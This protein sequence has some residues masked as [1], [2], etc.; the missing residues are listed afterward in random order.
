MGSLLEVN[1]DPRCV[2][3]AEAPVLR[4]WSP[5]RAFRDLRRDPLRFFTDAAR[6]GD[7]VRLQTWFLRAYLVSHP[8]HIRYVLKDNHRNYRNEDRFNRIFQRAGGDG[9]LTTDGDSWRR[10]RRLS[11]PAFSRERA[12][13]AVSVMSAETAAMLE[14]WAA[15]AAIGAQVELC[16]EMTRLTLQ[17]AGRAFCG[18]DM[19][20][21]A[22]TFADAMAVG[23]EHFH[24]R[25]YNAFTIPERIP[26]RRNL[27][28]RAASRIAV[29]FI[30][31]VIEPVLGGTEITGGAGEHGDSAANLLALLNGAERAP[32]ERPLTRAQVR[33]AIITFFGAASESTAVALAWIWYL[34]ATHP[35]VER[36][37][38]REIAAALCGRTPAA[39]DLANL[40]YTRMVI[41]EALRLY[42]PAWMMLRTA[43]ADDEIGGCHV[44]AGSTLLMSPW[45]T[46]RRADLWNDPL[47]FDPERFSPERSDG[48]LEYSFVPFG[49]GPR[50]CIGEEFAMAEMTLVVAMIAQRF[51]LRLLPGHQV[52]PCV[53]FTMR[54]RNGVVVTLDPL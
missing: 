36:R 11:Q 38:R 5:M 24:H 15:G 28:F 53:V 52:E 20:G 43:I 46:H 27:R 50:H 7:V 35:E 9:L 19:S 1:S 2:T 21:S 41:Q 30:E 25:L 37:L 6:L 23:F 17:I 16:R 42:P 31:S 22:D 51:R 45:V 47:R 44:P 10:Q 3:R 40:R 8:A 39:R 32:S 49:G 12:A 14:C 34:V 18:A 13:E 48:R 54:P 4:Y 29:A 33:D 26:T